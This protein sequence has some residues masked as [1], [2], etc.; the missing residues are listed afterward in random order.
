MCPPV[1]FF[2]YYHSTS[3]P[4]AWDLVWVCIDLDV[5]INVVFLRFVGYLVALK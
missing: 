4:A 3:P 1:I 5:V 2:S